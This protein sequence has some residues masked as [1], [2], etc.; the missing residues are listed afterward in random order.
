M[1]FRV[2]F[3]T[4]LLFLDTVNIW[5]QIS[6]TPSSLTWSANDVSSKVVTVH[7]PGYWETDSTN[8]N[9]HYSL[10]RYNGYDGYEVEITPFSANTGSSSIVENI[11]FWDGSG[12]SCLQLTH[13]A[14]VGTLSVS[15]SSLSWAYN[16]TAGK[17]LGIM[18]SGAWTAGTIADW[19]SLS[20]SS[21][22]GNETITVYATTAN[23]SSSQRPATLY[24]TSGSNLTC[25]VT[26]TQAGNP[27]ASGLTTAPT[28]LSW[29]AE[30]T[31]AKTVTIAS[32]GEWSADTLGF[33]PPT[34]F[35][36]GATSG[37][38]GAVISIAPQNAN[39]TAVTTGTATRGYAFTVAGL[40][41]TRQIRDA[42]N[43]TV[44]DFEYS[45]ASA[46]GN[47]SWRKDNVICYQESFTYDAQNR[48][49]T[50]RQGATADGYPAQYDYGT[51]DTYFN[52]KGNVTYRSYD[53]ELDNFIDYTDSTDPYKATG[54]YSMGSIPDY[55]P[56]YGAAPTTSFDR[57]AGIARSGETVPS[58]TFTYNAEGERTKMAR[59]EDAFGI[60][61]NRY[62]LGGV[63]ERDENTAP[64]S[65]TQNAER[66][67]LGGSAY[68]APMV[69]VKSADVNN[70]TWTPFNIGRDVQG[71]ITEVLGTD[72]TTVETFRYDPW[73]L[74]LLLDADP[75]LDTLVVDDPEQIVA[76]SVAVGGIS[77][78]QAGLSVYV[79]SHGYTGHEHLYGYGLI[80]CNARLYDPA[81]GRFLSPDPL[82]Q[83]PSS[84]QNFNR[85]SYCLNNPL[86]YTDESGE[87]IHILVGGLIGGTLNLIANW[88]NCDGFWEYAAAFGAG[89]GAGAL[90]ASTGG[91]AGGFLAS[92]G[93][94]LL[95]A[96][97]G[98]TATSAINSI[99]S[100]TEN[101]FSKGDIDWG[102]V[103]KSSLVGGVSGV[104]GYY[105]GGLASE[106]MG[107]VVFNGIQIKSPVLAYALKSGV[108]G[109]AGG[110]AG[111]FATGYIMTGSAKQA[112]KMSLQGALVGGI[113]GGSLGAARGYI[114]ARN[115]GI[116]PW[117]GE[118]TNNIVVQDYTNIYSTATNLREKL[119]IEEALYNEGKL[120]VP[121]EKIGDF[122]WQGWDKMQYI[123]YS[124]TGSIN[125][126]YY[127]RLVD[128]IVYRGGFKIKY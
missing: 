5:A 57:P 18:C 12:T 84:T 10:S 50:T 4:V 71:S 107:D 14:V 120:I 127:Q 68:D 119:A 91:A 85:Y 56:E 64:G 8:F 100:Q 104:A 58:T 13:S 79:G 24:V 42:C 22:S 3:V 36:M 45:Y 96:T 116:N 128:G 115:S 15:P 49:R 80:N 52:S 29:G 48:L 112:W 28:L 33:S 106:K 69:L 73:G 9:S 123:H 72:G 121:S 74:A 98:G 54:W 109:A 21:G 94:G 113:Q 20:K 44:Q 88:N 103:G 75:A 108:G 78:T 86:K 81:L 67:F 60:H 124:E 6:F 23:P 46:T 16:S 11:P 26:L 31:G 87:W 55:I 7:S 63:Y 1:R 47:M 82:I 102:Q 95:S 117:T 37:S 39:R 61:M 38:S 114:Y 19:I 27:N 125:V 35:S 97:I 99:I 89:A 110:F 59:D 40:P 62:Y 51:A 66:L 111:G 2:F 105:I 53:G 92:T 32:S 70:G 118:R 30:E 17:S 90:T 83:N 76:D 93:A 65:V 126:H 77:W 43:N 34:H 122:R 25:S 101:N 41:S